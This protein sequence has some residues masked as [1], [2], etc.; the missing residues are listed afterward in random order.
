MLQFFFKSLFTAEFN[1]FDPFLLVFGLI[2]YENHVGAA[3]NSNISAYGGNVRFDIS[4]DHH[5]C[6]L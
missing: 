1:F 5:T 6:A 3:E 2:E 4:F